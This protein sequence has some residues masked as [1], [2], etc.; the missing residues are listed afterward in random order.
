VKCHSQPIP[1]GVQM[2]GAHDQTG[3]PCTTC[4]DPHTNSF[5]AP[6]GSPPG[7][8]QNPSA[9][10]ENCHKDVAVTAQHSIHGAANVGCVDCHMGVKVTDGTNPH[11]APDHTANATL[12]ACVACHSKEMH[13]SA[14]TAAATEAPASATPGTLGAGFLSSAPSPASPLGY[15]VISLL[16]GLACGFALAPLFE[17]ASRRRRG[18]K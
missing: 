14:P 18:G 5:Q 3:M 9:L 1:E 2:S 12:N 7:V 6:P 8:L 15:T 13:A 17:R 10:C 16:I 11:A 4:H